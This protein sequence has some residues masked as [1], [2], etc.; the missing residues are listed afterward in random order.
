M[1]YQLAKDLDLL[2]PS[3]ALRT[4]SINLFQSDG[5]EISRELNDKLI[6]LMDVLD[7]E[8]EE[9]R[10]GASHG[11]TVE[12]RLELYPVFSSIKPLVSYFKTRYQERLKSEDFKDIDPVIAT[13]FL[14]VIHR[15]HQ[16]MNATDSWFDA[17]C[18]GYVESID[19]DGDQ[20]LNWKG[21]G[22]RTVLDL[23]M[24]NIQLKH[25]KKQ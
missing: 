22:Y 4:D 18:P 14:Q 6:Q 5:T 12:L 16:G 19:A 13:Q 15:Y 20:L 10:P 8:S 25:K 17:S 2:E 21:K 24:V 23:L 7:T 1:V 9:C 11:D 3:T